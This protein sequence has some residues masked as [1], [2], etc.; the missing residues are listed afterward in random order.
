MAKAKWVKNEKRWK[1]RVQINKK[2]HVFTSRRAGSVGKKECEMKYKEFCEKNI[3]EADYVRMDKTIDEVWE[4]YLKHCES[5]YGIDSYPYS[6]AE[7]AGRL[8][9]LPALSGKRMN[10]LR[11]DDFQNIINSATPQKNTKKVLS[12]KYLSTLR[13]N[14]NAFT[15]W[16]WQNDYMNALKGELYI[17][18]DRPFYGKEVLQ[19]EDICRLFEPSKL[20]YHSLFCF[21]A[22]TGMRPGEG[23][24]LQTDDFLGDKVIIRR[25]VN[26]KNQITPGKN[27]NANRIV[28]LCD[29]ARSLM[30][31]TIARNKAEGLDTKW[32]FCSITGGP[33]CQNTMQNQWNKLKKE[34]NLPGTPYSLRG[35]WISLFKNSLTSQQIKAIVGHSNSMPTFEVYSKALNGEIDTQKMILNSVIDDLLES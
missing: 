29:K 14:I 15:K 21:L 27:K 26:R 19:P 33:G 34:R 11:L 1:L 12:K 9:V 35:T 16:A 5:R 7:R 31:D 23:L 4:R 10:K 25:S 32:I 20:F 6:D 24:G 2:D 3:Y 8:F 22:L 17:P 28:P 30:E 13:Y 18:K